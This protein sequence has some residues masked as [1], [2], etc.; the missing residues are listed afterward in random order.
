MENSFVRM[1]VNVSVRAFSWNK[2]RSTYASQQQTE[3]F[4]VIY[5]P[6]CAIKA[7]EKK[8][9]ISNVY[10]GYDCQNHAHLDY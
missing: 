6:L 8:F 5:N 4:K 1:P 9:N 7:K 10:I 2:K 3:S